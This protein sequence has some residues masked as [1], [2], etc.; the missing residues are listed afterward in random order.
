MRPH[1]GG[2]VL[3]PIQFLA[4]YARMLGPT[5][6]TTMPQAT[7]GEQTDLS[8]TDILSF[9]R[10]ARYKSRIHTS[11]NPTLPYMGYREGPMGARAYRARNLPMNFRPAVAA[12]NRTSRMLY[13]G[14]SHPERG[15]QKAINV[16]HIWKRGQ[17]RRKQRNVA[18]PISDDAMGGHMPTNT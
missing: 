1:Y 7:L 16:Y 9:R 13:G 10:S 17:A 5:L 15:P 6:T 3:R 2:G 4:N 11:R 14:P 8:T 18:L 12:V